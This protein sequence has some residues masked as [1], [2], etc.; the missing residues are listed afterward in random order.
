MFPQTTSMLPCDGVIP[1]GLTKTMQH[2]FLDIQGDI[3]S[4]VQTTHIPGQLRVHP[5]ADMYV[6]G[7]MS[8]VYPSSVALHT[9]SCHG[10]TLQF[11]Q[12]CVCHGL[13]LNKYL[14]TKEQAARMRTLPPAITPSRQAAPTIAPSS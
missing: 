7:D 13:C 5:H 4:G 14:V 2:D 9:S 1:L 11:L 10:A 3:G 8:C 6:W 12:I